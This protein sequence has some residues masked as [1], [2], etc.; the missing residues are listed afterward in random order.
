MATFCKRVKD[1]SSSIRIEAEHRK[2]EKK[3]DAM[4]VMVTV[5]LP[6]KTLYVE[7]RRADV[8]EAADRC[9]EKLEPQLK[10]YKDLHTGKGK[11]HV[12]RRK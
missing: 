12:A 9:V 10:K 11:A 1:E 4:K 5:S 2:T 3:Q 7:S 8:L 6:G